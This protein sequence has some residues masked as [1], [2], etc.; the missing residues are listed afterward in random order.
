M[1][2]RRFEF[3]SQVSTIPFLFL[4]KSQ[5][6]KTSAAEA[7]K[8]RCNLLTT[9]ITYVELDDNTGQDDF[10]LAYPLH[11]HLF[12]WLTHPLLSAFL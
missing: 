2:W 1:H 10:L 9:D 8:A 7:D 11:P 4:L 12:S 6:T 3:H 5:I